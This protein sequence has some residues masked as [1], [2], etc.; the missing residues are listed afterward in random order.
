MNN[1]KYLA[2]GIYIDREYCKETE[3]K[4]QILC[5]YLKAARR[6]PR[7][8]RKCRLEGPE[9]ILQGVTYTVDT[10]DK[11]PEE[12]KGPSISSKSDSRTFGF[13]VA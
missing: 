8:Q 7:Y 5:P 3:E 11:L 13:L 10:L 1:K 4:R 12:L 6:L 2:K 9:L